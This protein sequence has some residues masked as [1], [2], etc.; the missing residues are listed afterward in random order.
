MIT[1]Q[2]LF[3]QAV[4]QLDE[5]DRLAMIE[6]AQR[7]A[8]AEREALVASVAVRDGHIWCNGRRWGWLYHGDNGRWFACT[9]NTEGHAYPVGSLENVAGTGWPTPEQAARAFVREREPIPNVIDAR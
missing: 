3:D 7:D 8:V 1:G 2:A 9:L 6:Q 5:R 4:A